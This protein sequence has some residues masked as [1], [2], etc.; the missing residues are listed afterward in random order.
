MDLSPVV[1]VLMPVYNGS[2]YL[3]DAVDSILTQT[4]TNFEFLII[5]DMSIDNSFEILKS[6]NDDRIRLIKNEKNIGL[7][8]SL[9]KGLNLA[10]GKYIARMD[11][12]DIS[13]PNR[14]E[15]QIEY[16]KEHNDICVLGS[17]FKVISG[18]DP[19]QIK[20]EYRWP[21]DPETCAFLLYYFGNSPIGHPCVMFKKNEIKRLGGYNVKYQIA[22]DLELW[23]KV[24][25]SHKRICNVP[26]CLFYWREHDTNTSN[27]VLTIREHNNAL[28]QFLS[29]LI[30]ESISNKKSRLY[31]PI[32]WTQNYKINNRMVYETLKIKMEVLKTFTNEYDLNIDMAFKFSKDIWESLQNFYRLNIFG[33]IH[34][35]FIASV[36]CIRFILRL[37]N[38]QIFRKFILHI[39][40][41]IFK[42]VARKIRYT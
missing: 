15:K 37:K 38:F 31:R 39:Y 21:D 8:A 6:Y 26:I 42:K 33:L 29:V 41:S 32:N 34:F 25:L 24:L 7:S 18:D 10:L 36:F 35:T 14:L 2:K 28:S 22:N 17:W 20:K 11:Q 13:L 27:T 12:D 40:P 5:D 16:F 3:S 23:L 1:S 4:Y 19:Y 30:G 9:N